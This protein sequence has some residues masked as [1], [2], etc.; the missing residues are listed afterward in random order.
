VAH[1]EDLMDTGH[2]NAGNGAVDELTR[3]LRRLEHPIETARAAL[4]D[5]ALAESDS[6]ADVLGR[7]IKSLPHRPNPLPSLPDNVTELAA[8]R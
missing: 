4:R 7:L 8:W 5:A 6:W 1:Q 2:A 3:E